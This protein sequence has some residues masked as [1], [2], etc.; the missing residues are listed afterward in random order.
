M[1]D[2]HA[3]PPL[4]LD[5]HDE[6]V[7]IAVRAL[8]DM[9]SG[10]AVSSP[11]STCVYPGYLVKIMRLTTTPC[12][13]PADACAVYCLDLEHPLV[14]QPVSPFGR[15]SIIRLPLPDDHPAPRQ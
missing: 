1:T 9:R 11:P 13:I 4:S 14:G 3:L 7:R 6:S 2:I 8:G 12:S 15:C 5:E 10:A